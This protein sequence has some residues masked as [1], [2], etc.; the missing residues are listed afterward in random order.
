MGVKAAP[1]GLVL[2]LAVMAVAHHIRGKR[3]KGG[4]CGADRRPPPTL[5]AASSGWVRCQLSGSAM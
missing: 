4:S 1:L 3:A 5:L 2:Q